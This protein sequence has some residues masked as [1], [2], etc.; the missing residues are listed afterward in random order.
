MEG[1]ASVIINL[2]KRTDDAGDLIKAP[3]PAM[4]KEERDGV[5]FGAF[6]VDKVNVESPKATDVNG[7]HELRKLIK[8]GLDI[9]PVVDCLPCIYQPFDLANRRTFGQESFSRSSWSGKSAR[10]NFCIRRSSLEGEMLIL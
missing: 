3:R 2:N 1:R 6:L 10:A 9:A 7:S 5:C 8:P 4:E